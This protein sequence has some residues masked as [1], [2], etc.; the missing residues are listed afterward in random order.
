MLNAQRLALYLA[1][2]NPVQITYFKSWQ[3]SDDVDLTIYNL[4]YRLQR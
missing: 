4:K 1:S 3:Y 2:S